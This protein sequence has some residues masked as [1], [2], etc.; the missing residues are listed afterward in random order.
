[1]SFLHKLENSIREVF[2]FFRIQ[3]LILLKEGESFGGPLRVFESSVD[4][5][6]AIVNLSEFRINRLGSFEIIAGAP[7]IVQSQAVHSH[8]VKSR[9]VIGVQLDGL[10]EP[11]FGFL[12]VH[13]VGGSDPQIVVGRRIVGIELQR[14]AQNPLGVRL[15]PHVSKCSTQQQV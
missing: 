15:L 10:G 1:M 7:V 5:G 14:P 13:L 12:I 3:L 6:K 9:Q 4:H 11:A 8:V 2:S